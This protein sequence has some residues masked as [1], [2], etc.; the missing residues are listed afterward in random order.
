[1]DVKMQRVLLDL[2]ESDHS[3]RLTPRGAL[4]YAAFLGELLVAEE[5]IE[6]HPQGAGSSEVAAFLTEGNEVFSDVVFLAALEV[7]IA[8]LVK[9]HRREWNNPDFF[10]E[11]YAFA[12]LDMLLTGRDRLEYGNTAAKHY[13]EPASIRA[14]I[15]AYADIDPALSDHIEGLLTL[16]KEGLR[17]WPPSRCYP[18]S[19]WWR[20]KWARSSDKH[21]T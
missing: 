14:A 6:Q 9:A 8:A 10:A 16:F 3:S 19:F 15:D 17:A 4:H 7:G 12:E 18:A 11:A 1:M 2:A 20:P 21:G 13:G 5:S